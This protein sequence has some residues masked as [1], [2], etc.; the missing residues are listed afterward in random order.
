MNNE[1]G[2]G[3][4]FDYRQQLNVLTADEMKRLLIG[5]IKKHERQYMKDIL[6]LLFAWMDAAEA[7]K[8]LALYAVAK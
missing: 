8:K 4:W 2:C 7:G 3:A 1:D 6:L 5:A